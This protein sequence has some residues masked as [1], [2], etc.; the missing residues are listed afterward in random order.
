MLKFRDARIEVRGS[1]SKEFSNIQTREEVRGND[2][3]LEETTIAVRTQSVCQVPI[4][5][6]K[7]TKHYNDELK[8]VLA[9]MHKKGMEGTGWGWVV[10]K[11]CFI[12]SIIKESVCGNIRRDKARRPTSSSFSSFLG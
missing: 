11:G 10:E 5:Y 1:R 12:V 6:C 3:F 8:P 4:L 2:L 7:V 9:S